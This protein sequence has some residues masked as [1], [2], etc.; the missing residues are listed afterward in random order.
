MERTQFTVYGRHPHALSD[1][2]KAIV[3]STV[4]PQKA[5]FSHKICRKTY[6][7]LFQHVAKYTVKLG[8]LI[9]NTEH[10]MYTSYTGHVSDILMI[11]TTFRLSV[12]IVC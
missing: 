10:Q 12:P 6:W 5:T 11:Q 8:G 1:F 7:I 2:Q 4:N 3:N 9:K